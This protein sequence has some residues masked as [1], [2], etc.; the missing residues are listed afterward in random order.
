M[1]I[2]KLM[3]KANLKRIFSYQK[4]KQIIQDFSFTIQRGDK[5][6]IIGA[7]G[8]GKTTLIKLLLGQLM[9]ISGEV[10]P[11][12]ANKMAF[13]DPPTAFHCLGTLVFG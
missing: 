12:P 3:R 1:K 2:E 6:S 7:N 9:P 10:K 13:F 8:S 5:V 4:D 11:S